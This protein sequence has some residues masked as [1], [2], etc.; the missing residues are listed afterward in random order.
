MEAS[1]IP[2]IQKIKFTQ[3]QKARRKEIL[4]DE[5]KQIKLNSNKDNLIL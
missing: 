3:V 2:D 5:V 4:K 1:K